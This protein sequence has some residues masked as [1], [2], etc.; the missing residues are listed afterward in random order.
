VTID[1]RTPAWQ[2]WLTGLAA[3]ASLI[4]E[5]FIRPTRSSLIGL[6][7]FVFILIIVTVTFYRN[8]ISLRD[9]MLTVRGLLSKQSVYLRALVLVDVSQSKGKVRY[10]RLVF[11]DQMGH[12]VNINF[13]GLRA[14]ERDQL[15]AMIKPW[16][17]RPGVRLQGPVEEALTG[18][19]W[20][21]T[22]PRTMKRD[23]ETGPPRHSADLCQV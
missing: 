14:D 20:W 11:Q 23:R 1:I 9:E 6:N 21:S 16:A 8:L 18:R 3:C 12:S 7:I 5:F 19:L 13:D 10:W 4:P 22:R 15:L 2:M 17:L